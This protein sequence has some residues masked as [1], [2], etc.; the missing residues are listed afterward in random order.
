M[1]CVTN[2]TMGYMPYSHVYMFTIATELYTN[3]QYT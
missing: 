3:Y 2:I 1:T